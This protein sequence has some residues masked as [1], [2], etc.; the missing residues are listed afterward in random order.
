MVASTPGSSSGSP[1]EFDSSAESLNSSSGHSRESGSSGFDAMPGFV[2][3]VAGLPTQLSETHLPAGFNPRNPDW[4]P[5]IDGY[6]IKRWLGGGGYG[7]VYL[8]HNTVLD[9]PVAIKVL[10]P[11]WSGVAEHIERF[12]REVTQTAQ[13][14]HR[15]IVHVMNTGRIRSGVWRNCPFMAM[16]YLTGGDFQDWLSNHPRTSRRDPSLRLAVQKIAEVCEGL[17]A[18][19]E[20]GLVHRDIKP[21]NILLDQND[22]PRL[23]D[24]G[25]ADVHDPRRAAAHSK[26]AGVM[27]PDDTDYA[28]H[29]SLTAGN[30]IV[31]TRGYIAPELFAGMQNASPAS[32]QYA[33]GVILYQILCDLRPFQNHRQD[34]DEGQR[35]RA[36]VEES[37]AG[38]STG[39][40]VPPSSKSVFRDPGLQYICLRCLRPE[41][42][43]RYQNIE[44]LRLDLLRWLNGE[45]VQ[46]NPLTRFWNESIYRPVKSRP[47]WYVGLTAV[48]LTFIGL[49]YGLSTSLMHQAELDDALKD[50]N[51][52]RTQLRHQLVETLIAQGETTASDG[53]LDLAMLSWSAAW[54]QALGSSEPDQQQIRSLQLRLSLAAMLQPQLQLTIPGR[55]V[56]RDASYSAAGDR[57][58]LNE[59]GTITIIDP[60]TGQRLHDRLKLPGALAKFAIS[61]DAS[62]IATWSPQFEGPPVLA[63]FD[64]QTGERQLVEI[65]F[66]VGDLAFTPDCRKIIVCSDDR[67]PEPAGRLEL[68]DGFNL[69]EIASISFAEKASCLAVHPDGS[70]VA[71]V[72]IGPD[73]RITI[74]ATDTLVE[75][76]SLPAP[77][78]RAICDLS[79]SPDGNLLA[80]ASCDG[81]V[82]LANMQS[83]EPPASGSLLLQE[84]MLEGVVDGWG[85]N[86]GFVCFS[87]DSRRLATVCGDRTVRI[88][89]TSTR[90][91]SGPP[92]SHPAHITAISFSPDHNYILTSSLNNLARIWDVASAQPLPGSLRHQGAVLTAAFH[93]QGTT[94]YTASE[95]GETRIWKFQPQNPVRPESEAAMVMQVLSP[96]ATL[97]ATQ[98]SMNSFRV[99]DA[100]S[101]QPA[102]PAFN[103]SHPVHRM[104]FSGDGATLALAGT[105]TDDQ[106][107]VSL[108]N[109]RT[110]EF[111]GEKFP[112]DPLPLQQSFSPDGRWLAVI[113]ARKSGKSLWIYDCQNR[114]CRRFENL[115]PDCL[116]WHP[117]D[118]QDLFVGSRD[119]R[120]LRISLPDFTSRETGGTGVHRSFAVSPSAPMAHC[121]R[122]SP[123]MPFACCRQP[124]SI[125]PIPHRFGTSRN[126]TVQRFSRITGNCSPGET[127]GLFRSGVG[128]ANS[129]RGSCMGRFV[130]RLRSIGPHSI[131]MAVCLRLPAATGQ[132]LSGIRCPAS[133]QARH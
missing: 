49:V 41:P 112:V 68:R 48:V 85:R 1:E 104:C 125:P 63:L 89:D 18:L 47:L 40:P 15:H 130:T 34:P 13:N 111:I 87:A 107:F 109:T 91:E 7:C 64:V 4:W 12:V 127:M 61:P 65:D 118:S 45:L 90:R 110:G 23:A 133:Q 59:G 6:V 60:R 37:S 36:A 129:S 114:T 76:Q 9:C 99:F 132:S 84:A 101:L 51:A 116:V 80:A 39:T 44:A 33:V 123:E 54:G 17:H 19:H 120:I 122:R 93:P 46:D 53:E 78:N 20:A 28:P 83:T 67:S 25:L 29:V 131:P 121:W 55:Q 57:L 16:E 32:D 52:A 73:S 79:Y 98:N 92:L 103:C 72:H 11:K 62:R 119:S 126:P 14:H 117:R 22:V 27:L 106:G 105:T 3:P 95:D 124:V 2:P 58:I 113:A 50:A 70:K 94:L 31:G 43:L 77:P 75:Q 96:D 71:V 74:H 66:S 128:P 115:E 26:N 108:V 8:A 21:Q 5:I 82:L 30:E 100:R 97:L 69:A 102:S 42:E 81:I 10:N 38:P 86:L 56:I 35:I 88:W 24:L